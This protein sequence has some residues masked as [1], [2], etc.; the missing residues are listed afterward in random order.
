MLIRCGA[1]LTVVVLSS[2][3]PAWSDEAPA[4]PPPQ[5]TFIGKGQF[6][7]LDS[8]GNTDAE[9]VNANLV[10]QRYD[11]D[12]KNEIFLGGLYGKSGNVVSAE[13]WEIRHQADYNITA[14][15]F[16]FGALRF[17]HDM[18]NGFV[19]Q[20]SATGG[21][22]YKFFD[23]N[24]TKLTVQAG[25]GFRRL[26]PQTLI[27]DGSGAVVERDVQDPENEAVGVFGL[28]FS[29]AFNKTTSVGNKLLIE[30]GASNTL[31]HDDISLTV[32]M[33]TKLALVAGYGFIDNTSPP[34]GVKSLDTIATINVQYA[35]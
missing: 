17:E 12:W 32:K 22:G 7:F 13:R 33:S 24:D 16:A 8:H 1:V 5:H 3:I 30:A 28:E 20:G 11:G 34:A 23:T 15:L 2:A 19:Y 14:T 21:L 4:P 27:K 6:G 10:I 31:I 26:R 18:F 25:G 29:H 35:F 9:T